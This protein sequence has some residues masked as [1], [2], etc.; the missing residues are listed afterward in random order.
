ME[1]FSEWTWTETGGANW[2]LWTLSAF[3]RRMVTVIVRGDAWPALRVEAADCD[4]GE[5]V[6][7]DLDTAKRVAEAIACVLLAI[8]AKS[9]VLSTEGS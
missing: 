8:P 4:G 1:P 2:K 3:D 9:V 5:L 7:S 6:F